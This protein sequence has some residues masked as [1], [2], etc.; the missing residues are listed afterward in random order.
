MGTV[1]V[2]GKAGAAAGIA[3]VLGVPAPR[4][5][6]GSQL[7]QLI[8]GRFMPHKR[9]LGGLSAVFGSVK[10]ALGMPMLGRVGTAGF[11]QLR[12]TKNNKK[13]SSKANS[14]QRSQD[15]TLL[16]SSTAGLMGGIGGAAAG[17]VARA[18]TD[19]VAIGAAAATLGFDKK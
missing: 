7:G 3:G 4:P 5:N 9:L 1:G 19:G 11:V 10:L 8:L 12:Q 15:H 14:S 17:V 18:A 2:L 13:L 16:F 6:L